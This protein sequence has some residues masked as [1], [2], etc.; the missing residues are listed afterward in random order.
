M[1]KFLKNLFSEN[2]SGGWFS[3]TQNVYKEK[4]ENSIMIIWWHILHYLQS[5]KKIFVEN[6]VEEWKKEIIEKKL[7]KLRSY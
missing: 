1:Q 4:Y 2:T 7:N 3:V 6:S 5:I